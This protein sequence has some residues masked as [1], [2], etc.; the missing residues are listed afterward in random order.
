MRPLQERKHLAFTLK[1]T[2]TIVGKL[3]RI[4]AFIIHAA[5]IYFYLLIF[6]VSEHLHLS[7]DAVWAGLQPTCS[8]KRGFS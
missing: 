3:E 8:A 2:R 4:C 6:N 5:F 1:D 7:V